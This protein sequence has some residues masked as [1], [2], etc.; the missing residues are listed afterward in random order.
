[1][2]PKGNNENRNPKSLGRIGYNTAFKGNI[3]L[4][5]N[6]SVKNKKLIARTPL[7]SKMNIISE[8][9]QQKDTKDDKVLKYP[10]LK[11]ISSSNINNNS[12]KN[13]LNNNII[14]EHDTYNGNAFKDQAE[15]FMHMN[16]DEIILNNDEENDGNFELVRPKLNVEILNEFNPF[17]NI[18]NNNYVFAAHIDESGKKEYDDYFNS[19]DEKDLD[20]SFN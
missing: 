13:D 8:N 14:E 12:F 20:D 10:L 9:P 19:P 16:Q 2:E 17:G 11:S 1:M 6:I 15:D 7:K 18:G 3:Q 5:N 4:K